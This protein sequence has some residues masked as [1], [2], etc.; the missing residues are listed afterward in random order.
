MIWAQ[1]FILG[2]LD[3]KFKA[4]LLTNQF[5]IHHFLHEGHWNSIPEIQDMLSPPLEYWWSMQIQHFL[6]TVLSNCAESTIGSILP[7]HFL[8]M[9]YSWFP[10]LWST[11]FLR[12][13]SPSFC[14]S[15][16][17]TWIGP[18]QAN[19]GTVSFS[20]FTDPTSPEDIKRQNI[21]CWRIGTRLP[22]SSIKFSLWFYLFCLFALPAENLLLATHFL[23]MP[24][25]TSFLGLCLE[26]DL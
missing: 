19:R 4:F 15:G 7:E 5:R 1:E 18:W 3:A 21:N 13:M 8:T 9:S 25:H 20:L 14:R 10:I 17:M 24:P 23:V 22:L 2:L 12:N 6:N 11:N 16:S 26:V